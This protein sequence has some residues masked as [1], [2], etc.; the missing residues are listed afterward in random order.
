MD[1]PLPGGLGGTYGGSPVASAASLAVLDI[2]KEENLIER[3]V[4]IGKLFN[5]SLSQLKVQFP[6]L[7]CDVRN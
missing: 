2:I 4:Q 1:A 7:I 3:S 6:K 5:A